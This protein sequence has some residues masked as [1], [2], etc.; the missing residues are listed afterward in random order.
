MINPNINDYVVDLLNDNKA[1]FAQNEGLKVKIKDL[2]KKRCEIE[3]YAHTIKQW[4]YCLQLTSDIIGLYSVIRQ[5]Q[6]AIR[7]NLQ[8]IEGLKNGTIKEI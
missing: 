3:K 1:Y 7:K 4:S 6:N 5:N 2:T 8:K